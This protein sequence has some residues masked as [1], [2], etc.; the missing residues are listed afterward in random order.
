[1]EPLKLKKSTTSKSPGQKP[2]RHTQQTGP[3]TIPTRLPCDH[4]PVSVRRRHST[5][6][7]QQI[8]QPQLQAKSVN[9]H[10]KLPATKIN[11]P[12]VAHSQPI[13]LLPRGAAAGD[14]RCKDEEQNRQLS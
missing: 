10:S 2:P 8:H 13:H 11:A 12:K 14:Q 6:R 1:M 5:R 7:R 4:S 9:H 3:T